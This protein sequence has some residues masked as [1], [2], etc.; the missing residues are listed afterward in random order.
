MVELIA[1][2]DRMLVMNQGTVKGEL[3]KSDFSEKNIMQLILGEN[4]R[5]TM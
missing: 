3:E 1:M 5:S 4:K 2:C